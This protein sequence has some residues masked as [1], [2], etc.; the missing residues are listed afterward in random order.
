MVPEVKIVVCI[1][2]L[3]RNCQISLPVRISRGEVDR[4]RKHLTGNVFSFSTELVHA[5][6]Q[7]EMTSLGVS[8]RLYTVFILF[9]FNAAAILLK[10]NNISLHLVGFFE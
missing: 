4:F 7:G 3:G 6:A 5:V 9:H 1:L 10:Q 8:Y 2:I